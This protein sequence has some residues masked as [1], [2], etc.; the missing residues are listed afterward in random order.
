M[1][2]TG[3]FLKEVFSLSL[4]S[5]GG[6]QVHLSY[7][8]RVFVRDKKLVDDNT[9][10]EYYSLCQ[11]LPGP[12]STQTLLAIAYRCFGP[13]LLLPV[14]L[15]WSLPSLLMMGLLALLLQADTQTQRFLDLPTKLLPAIAMGLIAFSSLRL[16]RKVWQSRFNL[17]LGLSLLAATCAFNWGYALPLIVVLGAFASL[18]LGPNIPG[19]VP[20]RPQTE[21]KGDW[22]SQTILPIA[23]WLVGGSSV[24]FIWKYLGLG[25]PLRIYGTGSTVFGGGQVLLPLL[26]EDFVQK[27]QTISLQD[28]LTG[29]SLVQVLPGPLFS[30][31]AF[32]CV[33]ELLSLGHSNLVSFI[34]GVTIGFI[35]FVP[36]ALFL[37][38]L[39]PIWDRVKHIKE[40]RKC[41][42]GMAAA[43]AALLLSTLLPIASGINNLWQW[44][45]AL[46]VFAILELKERKWLIR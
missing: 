3:A 7:F 24:F 23:I 33:K 21:Q 34:G 13:S 39:M 38:A 31:T 26:L 5:F 20:E 43:G 28:F 18:I 17:I 22:R 29:Y 10:L 15:I 2:S 4:L 8:E 40:V 12:T 42:P 32:P 44:A 46:S 14:L 16:C 25:L 36:P 27:S 9:L 1:V 45:I 30:F 35:I 19:I 6:P 11:L 41:L 37:M